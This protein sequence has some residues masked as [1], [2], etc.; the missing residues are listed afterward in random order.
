MI[1]YLMLLFLT[2]VVF[3][4]AFVFWAIVLW[5]GVLKLG[6]AKYRQ[7]RDDLKTQIKNTL[8]GELE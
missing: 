1:D 6:G 8:I 4:F 3:P 2:T 5:I 7:I